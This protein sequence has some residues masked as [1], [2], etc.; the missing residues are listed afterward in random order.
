[1]NSPQFFTAKLAG[2]GAALN[3][4]TGFTPRCVIA[5]NLTQ[6]SLT[7][8]TDTMDQAKGLQIDDSGAD[9]TNIL[10]LASAGISSSS[11]GFSLGTDAALNTASDVIHVLAF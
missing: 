11:Q 4:N 1:M 3:V 5:L 9:T 10:A 6:L 8:W 2:T 7:V